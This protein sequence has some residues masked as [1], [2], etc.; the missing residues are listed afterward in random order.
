M[1]D[2]PATMPSDDENPTTTAEE[3]AHLADEPGKT[4][5]DSPALSEQELV[6]E[7]VRAARARGED[8]TGP[9]GLLKT[10]TKSVLEAALDEEIGE[11]LGYDKHAAEG[12]DGGN[13]RNGARSKTVLTDNVGP[14]EIDVPRDRDGTFEPTIVRKRQRRL[15]DVDTIV[16][17]LYAKG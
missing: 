12:G 8:L 16:L 6:G 2:T 3:P 7:Q 4:A 9:N 14:V 13:S 15:E 11:H 1:T 17:S 10:V 5:P